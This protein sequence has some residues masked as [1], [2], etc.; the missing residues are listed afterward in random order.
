MDNLNNNFKKTPLYDEHVKR[1]GKIVEFGGYLLPVE[2]TSIVNEHNAVRENCGLFDVSHM[3]E[4]FITG[5]D[6]TKYLNYL[7]TSNVEKQ[8]DFRMQ[9]GMALYEDGNIVDDLMIYKY[10][11]EKYLIVVNASNTD[12]D[13]EWFLKNKEGFDVEVINK[14]NEYGQLALQGPK[15]YLEL[16][17]LS[18]F[19]F[20]NMK[21]Y[22]FNIVNINNSQFICSR[23][24]YT[25]GDGFEIY[26]SPQDIVNLFKTLAD[27]NV[28]LCGL[29]CRDTLRFEGALPLYGH[30]ISD[31][32]N[33]V[34]ACLNFACDYTKDFIGKAKLEEYKQ[35][36]TYKLVGI[37]LID[38]GIGRSGYEVLN[39]NEE[40]I[41]YITTGYLLPGHEKALA[42]ALV[43]IEYSQINTKVFIKVRKKALEA[44][45]RDRKFMNK[46]YKK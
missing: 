42:L 4:I 15:A 14:S 5:S 27:S 13:Y 46:I 23:S 16:N 20:D 41:G 37:E 18:D 34:M 22:D 29:G 36:P 32:I 11:N 17:K 3:G 21:F 33:P 9:Y 28:T 43:K 2:Y 25:G 35:N 12:K 31:K 1:G 30:E 24:G 40:E 44:F 39:E 6:S 10:N 45:V 26:G 38:K 8:S 7:L 19:N